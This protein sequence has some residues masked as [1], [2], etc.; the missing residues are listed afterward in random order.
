MPSPQEPWYGGHPPYSEAEKSTAAEIYGGGGSIFDVA[1]ALHC[2]GPRARAVICAAGLEIRPKGRGVG[3]K[4]PARN[5]PK[6]R[7]LKPYY[8]VFTK[9]EKTMTPEEVIANQRALDASREARQ[10]ARGQIAA[11]GL[12]RPGV[13]AEDPR[14]PWEWELEEAAEL[15]GLVPGA[16]RLREHAFYV[17]GRVY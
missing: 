8:P 2:A 9:S 12:V 13:P 14:E 10:L 17:A 15:D 1:C 16:D 11:A 3:R 4:R 6:I 7:E 5:T